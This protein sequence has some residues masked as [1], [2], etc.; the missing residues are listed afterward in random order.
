M[1][2]ENE[3]FAKLN[4]IPYVELQD[5]VLGPEKNIDIQFDGN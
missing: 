5:K 2:D 4:E 3:F 1:F